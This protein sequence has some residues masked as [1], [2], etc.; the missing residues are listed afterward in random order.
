VGALVNRRVST[1]PKNMKKITL[2]ADEQLIRRAKLVARTQG[3]SLNAAFR[4]WLVQFVGPAGRVK[5]VEALMM[6][7]RHIKVD[8]HFSREDMNK[9]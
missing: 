1:N 2:G 6:R 8:R 4:K 9:R 5:E 7:L 3:K